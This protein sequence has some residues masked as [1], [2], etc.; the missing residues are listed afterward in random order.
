MPTIARYR[1]LT[2]LLTAALLATLLVALTGGDRAVA[3]DGPVDVVYIATGRAFPDALSGSILAGASTAP[4]LTV[5][6]DPPLPEA[7]V[8]ALEALAPDRIVV[9]GGTAAVSAEVFEQ[10]SAF[11]R[12]N[13]VVRISGDD[14][15]A[16]AAAIAEALP[17]KV[18]DADRL[19]GLDADDFLRA[20]AADDFAPAD[21]DH[22]ELDQSDLVPVAWAHEP[23]GGLLEADNGLRARETVLQMTVDM[24]AEGV[25][26]LSSTA[27]LTNDNERT[28]RGELLVRVDGDA[29]R[30][31]TTS[32][33]EDG[34]NQTNGVVVVTVP[35][36]LAAGEHTVEVAVASQGP[37]GLYDDD[38]RMFYSV[39]ASATW[40]PSTTLFTAD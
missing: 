5:E 37:T 34:T 17:D 39:D 14:R 12:S 26:M 30:S 13:S 33:Q 35:L 32:F 20:S 9:F 6:P 10:L 28:M 8:T 2:V 7:T 23:V 36:R 27:S 40:T 18:A 4:L 19:D 3:V 29:I 15:H 11:A 21:H 31:A 1:L 16:T 38:H 25:V 24:P 22:P